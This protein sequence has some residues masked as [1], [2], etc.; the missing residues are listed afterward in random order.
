VKRVNYTHV[1]VERQGLHLGARTILPQETLQDNI[2]TDSHMF[3]SIAVRLG[4]A[5]VPL[6]HGTG[7]PPSTNTGAPFGYDTLRMAPLNCC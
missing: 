5:I 7:A 3:Y 2:V 4:L 6:R 1:Y